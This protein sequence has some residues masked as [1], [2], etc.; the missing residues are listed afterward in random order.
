ML[1]PIART[2]LGALRGTRAGAISVFRGIP[3]AAAPVAERRFLSPAPALP[4]S[5]VR[6]ALA[7]GP[8]P[9]QLSD[10]LSQRLGLGLGGPILEDCLQLNVWTP[11]AEAGARPVLVWIHG[12]AFAT[13]SGTAPLYDGARIAERGDCVV[14]TLNYRVGALGFLH[15]APFLADGAPS[16]QGTTEGAGSNLGLLDQI[17]ALS[18]VQRE[19]TH[20]GGD[21][22]CVTVFGESAGAGSIVALLAMPA[23]KG[24]FQR[25]IVQSPAPEGMLDADEGRERA[26]RLLSELGLAPRDRRVELAALQQVPV[27][28]LLEAQQ[29]C[30]AAG[31]HRT[32]MFFAPVVDGATLP[33]RPLEAVAG[34]RARDIE[35]VIGTTQE[36]MQLY[37]TIPGLGDFP[38][39]ILVR[40]VASRLAGGEASREHVARRAVDRY[41]AELAA[42]QGAAPS[43]RDLFFALETDLSLRLAST[44]LAA[45]QARFQ[46]HTFMY[47]FQW[48]SPLSDGGGGTL[49]ACH[50]LDLPFTF[51]ALEPGPARAFACG[52]DPKG[53]ADA[54]VLSDRIIDA[55]TAFARSGDPSHPGIGSWPPYDT[56]SRRTL[57]F[58][59][60]CCVCEA[61]L[62][63]MRAVWDE[64]EDP[65]RG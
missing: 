29:Q 42:A 31:P 10:P 64:P 14:V 33:V 22:G 32:G 47:L 38:D 41:R 35:L 60:D 12:G 20:F 5:G 36:E 23:A 3:F 55:W 27:D 56:E 4:W 28:R 45:S 50:A 53:L 2:S 8:A 58:G 59:R 65:T 24:L 57:L 37:R 48:R 18:F 51:G 62:E 19:I 13:G 40:I 54:R 34:G 16:R 61:P 7:R 26:A 9:P 21:P 17:A 43:Q 11:S 6:A 1:P 63:A 30:I 39:E 49:G 52:D 46:P 25:A 44:R 15:L